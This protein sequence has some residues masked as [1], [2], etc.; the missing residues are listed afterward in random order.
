MYKSCNHDDA[1]D[2]CLT[3][4]YQRRVIEELDTDTSYSR[5]INM[6]YLRMLIRVH[7][8]Y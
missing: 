7:A 8:V 4:H 2:L 5:K 1:S 3:S 6:N